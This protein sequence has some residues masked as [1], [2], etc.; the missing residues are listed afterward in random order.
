MIIC[1]AHRTAADPNERT[2]QIFNYGY[3]YFL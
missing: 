2:K 3:I 1:M